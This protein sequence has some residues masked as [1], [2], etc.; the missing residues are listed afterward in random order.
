MQGHVH[1]ARPG[2][3]K[4]QGRNLLRKWRWVEAVQGSDKFRLQLR[5]GPTKLLLCVFREKE[6]FHAKPY[7]VVSPTDW[8]FNVTLTA[9]CMHERADAYV[10]MHIYVYVCVYVYIYV[11]IYIHT[12]ICIYVYMYMYICIYMRG[13]FIFRNRGPSLKIHHG[14]CLTSMCSLRCRQAGLGGDGSCEWVFS[15]CLQHEL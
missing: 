4:K 15:S 8:I 14:Q 1:L 7:V 13:G 5:L 12:Y 2:Q 9:S 11:Y 10:C 6:S 3:K